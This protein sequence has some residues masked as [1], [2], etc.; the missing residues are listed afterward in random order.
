MP[1][2]DTLL[3]ARI[4]AWH[5]DKAG[6]SLSFSRRLANENGW[7]RRYALR[8]TEEYKRFAYLACVAAHPVTP[9]E[10]VD[11]VW[12]LHLI[13]TRSYWDEFCGQVLRRS[14]HHSPTEGGIMEARKYYAQY[15]RT[16]EAY[17]R[18]FG[19]EAP[20]DI[21]PPA[22]K[23][24]AGRQWRWVNLRQFWVLKRWF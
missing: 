16:L 3:W 18:E 7:T 6:V 9:S 12:H 8:A 15:E 21:W 20:A 2:T 4:N 19:E 10:A 23:R 24:F 1:L 5:P 11:Q 22:P 14:L 13:Y 17:I